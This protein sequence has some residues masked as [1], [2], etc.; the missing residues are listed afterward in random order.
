MIGGAVL[1]NYLKIAL[2]NLKRHKGYTFINIAGLAIG[3]ACC[4]LITALVEQ[5]LSSKL[6]ST[7]F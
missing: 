7:R 3:M 2:R 5:E 4:I 6:I 1:K